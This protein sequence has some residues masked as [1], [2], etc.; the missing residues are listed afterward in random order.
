M[1]AQVIYEGNASSANVK[2]MEAHD[3][4]QKDRDSFIVELRKRRDNAHKALESLNSQRE[5]MLGNFKVQEDAIRTVIAA[6][7]AALHHD[8]DQ[9]MPTTDYEQA[10]GP[11]EGSGPLGY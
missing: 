4:A 10:D 11:V 8:P 9:P 7:E 3:V 1:C 2:P 5:H 6:A